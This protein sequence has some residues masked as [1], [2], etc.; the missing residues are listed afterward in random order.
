MGPRLPCG[1]FTAT[2]S[3]LVIED[4][5]GLRELYRSSLRTAGYSV[6]AVEDGVS[7]LHILEGHVPDVIVLD[8][9]LPRLGGRDVH[10]ELKSNPAT[11]RVPIVVVTGT[12][13]RDL[14]PTDFIK[15][16][17]KP[18]HLDALVRA[19]DDAVRGFGRPT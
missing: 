11:S 2:L 19:V 7:A 3:V 6:T 10:R 8:L 17:R 1:V 9:M 15:V 12:D 5:A 16:L 4:D 14:N 13:A 18:I